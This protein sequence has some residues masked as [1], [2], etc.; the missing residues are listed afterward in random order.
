VQQKEALVS[1]LVETN[2]DNLPEEVGINWDIMCPVE[3][4]YKSWN[5]YWSA[6]AD[7]M[8][9]KYKYTNCRKK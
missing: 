6:F 5:D 3:K 1:K 4:D 9:E 2:F 8:V 7:Y